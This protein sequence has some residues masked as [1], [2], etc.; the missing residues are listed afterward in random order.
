MRVQQ[1]GPCPE[2]A[3]GRGEEIMQYNPANPLIVQGDRSVLLEVDNPLHAQ[4]RDAIAPFAELEKSPEHIHTYRLT[5][6]SLWNAA[7]AGLSAAEMISTLGKYSKFP[8]PPN[9]APDI[10]EL[11]SRYGRLH[12]P[13]RACFCSRA[14]TAP[15]STNWAGTRKFASSSGSAR[16]KTTTK[17]LTAIGAFS[18]RR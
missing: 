3:S 6:L 15:Y 17:W 16:V 5:P 12:R 11:V 2:A 9:L 10:A 18:N 1:Q 14:A 7:A 4:A 8:V 13:K